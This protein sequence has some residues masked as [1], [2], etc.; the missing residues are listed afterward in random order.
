MVTY[1][2][3]FAGGRPGAWKVILVVRTHFKTLRKV[4]M[5]QAI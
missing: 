3:R 4:I 5:K 1:R 2:N